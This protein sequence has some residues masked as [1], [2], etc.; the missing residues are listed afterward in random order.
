MP[1]L[2]PGAV[3]LL[4]LVVYFGMTFQV[5]R[6]RAKHAIAAPAVSGHPDFER[7]YRVQ[8]NTLEQLVVFLPLLWLFANLIDDE[9]AAGLGLLWIA[10]RLHYAFAYHQDPRTRGPGAYATI[11]IEIVLML[12]V[13]W[14]LL[15]LA[16]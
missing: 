5:A 15:V 4:A 1:V 9:W 16:L 8:M 3:T 10:A 7:A 13:A 11:G 14:G 6:M 2:Y 12:G